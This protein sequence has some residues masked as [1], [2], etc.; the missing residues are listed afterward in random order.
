MLVLDHLAVA[1]T[2]L[3]EGVEVVENTL[4]VTL[5]GGGEHALMGTHNQLLGLGDVYLEVIAINPDAPKPTYPRWFDLDNFAGAPRLSNWIC[6]TDDLEAAIDACPDGVGRPADLA[7]DDLR[8]RMAVPDDG[9]LPFSN[10]FPPLIQWKAAKHPADLLPESECRLVELTIA[11]PENQALE[12][13]LNPLFSD[14]RVKI[15]Y[16]EAV[17]MSAI[18][19]TPKGERQL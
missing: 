2:S 10:A 17:E 16:G 15:I 19:K 7:R 6:R 11:L 1:A 9:K 5:V 14:H 4:G 18:F 12:N 3:Q 13:A 8:W